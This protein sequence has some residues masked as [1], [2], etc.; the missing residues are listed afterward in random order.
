MNRT[1]KPNALQELMLFH[2]IAQE[3]ER[4][5]DYAPILEDCREAFRQ[6][7]LALTGKDESARHLT[8]LTLSDFISG[9]CEVLY[10]SDG[11]YSRLATHSITLPSGEVYSTAVLVGPPLDTTVA[12]WGTLCP[13]R[14]FKSNIHRER[15]EEYSDD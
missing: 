14:V 12:R 1:K 7:D 3:D 4:W 10:L 11:G 15:W 2:G 6:L 5:I 9:W 8:D 13:A